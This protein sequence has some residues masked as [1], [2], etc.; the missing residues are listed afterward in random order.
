VIIRIGKV[1]YIRRLKKRTIF[2]FLFLLTSLFA[3]CLDNSSEN[4]N[5]NSKDYNSSG[6]NSYGEDFV[7][8]LLNGSKKN[9]S[10]YR[11]KIVIL[12]FMGVNCPPCCLQMF[13]LEELY[14]NYNSEDVVILSIN[15]WIALGETIQD[16][17]LLKTAYS[18]ASPC[19]AEQKFNQL[20]YQWG[21][22]AGIK[23]SY[24]KQNGIDLDWT[25]GVDDNSGTLFAKY[26]PSGVPMLYI[27]DKKGNIYYRSSG[28]TEYD[29]LARKID[30]LI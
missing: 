14:S 29:L 21:G 8:T 7:F 28:Y 5:G 13:V 16:M 30:E 15:V 12:D 17:E 25:F 2:V 23:V 19:N 4:G 1:S 10:D 27:L 20:L 9:I 6:N 22:L 24:G 11:D 18:C 26:A 3:G